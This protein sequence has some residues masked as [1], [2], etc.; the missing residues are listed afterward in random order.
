MEPIDLARR[1]ASGLIEHRQVAESTAIEATMNSVGGSISGTSGGESI[2]LATTIRVIDGSLAALE[3]GTAA[4]VDPEQIQRFA[5]LPPGV[6][7]AVAL[8]EFCELDDQSVAA[9]VGRPVGVVTAIL[10]AVSHDPAPDF[11]SIVAAAASAGTPTPAPAPSPAP[12]PLTTDPP[13]TDTPTAG[14]TT[15]PASVAPLPLPPPVTVPVLDAPVRARRRS[16]KASTRTRWW[17][18]AAV[19]VLALIA[20]GIL[21]RN[22]R[23]SDRDSATPLEGSG[24]GESAMVRR[25][26]LSPACASADGDVAVLP[27]EVAIRS[28]DLGRTYRVVAPAAISPGLPRPL[29]IDFGDV[30]QAPA[31]HVAETRFD[32]LATALKVVVVT[33]SPAPGSPPQWNVTAGD[34]ADDDLL[35]D[36][37]VREVANRI[38]IDQTRVLL[39]GRG[40]G[41]HFAA[42]YACRHPG[43]VNG[44]ILVAGVFRTDE[45]AT[46]PVSMLAVL[47]SADDV[48]PLNGGTGS[49]FT[50]LSSGLLEGA[51]YEPAATSSSLDGWIGALDCAGNASQVVGLVRVR[52]SSSCLDD[53]E[54]WQVVLPDAGHEWFGA[55]YDLVVQFLTTGPLAP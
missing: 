7:A 11:A 32:S 55:T 33:V 27:E 31:D 5:A 17:V 3:R 34:G 8:S 53:T 4:A 52:I 24:V 13:T 54:I 21:A 51:V 26:Q 40:A 45:C 44:L 19:V 22:L 38:C 48:F 12:G 28:G 29:L 2:A 37:I 49:G 6:R 46:A 30:G 16:T 1:I 41:A 23:E 42:A 25:E 20:G 15:E 14:P 47:G 43:A 10:D 35:V 39:A 50:A 36:D 18:I 9:V